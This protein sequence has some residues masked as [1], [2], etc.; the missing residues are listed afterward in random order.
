MKITICGSIAFYD[1]MI[2][3]K[4]E[5]ETRG[6]EVL[7]PP[8]HVKDK[9]GNLITVAQYY[10]IRKNVDAKEQWI[11]ERKKEAILAHYT[12]IEECDVILVLNSDKNDI[13][14]YIGSNTLMEMGLA[15]YLQKP[16]YL[17]NEI[18]VFSATEE[19]RGMQPILLAGNL[20]EIK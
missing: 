5:L 18:P 12:K 11:W 7:L 17:F 6:H 9:N 4:K 19:V 10:E 14:G 1:N 3:V 20:A 13:A 15:L 8:T 16:I 2:A